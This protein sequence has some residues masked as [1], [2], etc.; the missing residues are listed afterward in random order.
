VLG[1][2]VAIGGI[3][4][5]VGDRLSADVPLASLVAVGVGV[6]FIALSNVIVKQIRP[7]TP[8]RPMRSAWRSERRSCWGL[9]C[10]SANR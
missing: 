1:A 7:V 2:L 5:I 8:S 10:W 9:P 4:V 6:G 3:A